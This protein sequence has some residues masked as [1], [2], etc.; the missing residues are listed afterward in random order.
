MLH[1]IGQKVE[2]IGRLRLDAA[3]YD[4][5]P[6]QAE[7]KRGPKPMKG[8]RQP[9]L[10][11]RLADPKTDWKTVDIGWYGGEQKSMEIATGIA[12]WHVPGNHP[13]RLRWILVRPV[14]TQDTSKGAAFFS[15]NVDTAPEQIATCYAQR[16]N[17]EVFFEEVRAC[18]GFETQRGW[19][20]RTIGRT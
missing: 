16:W 19:S 4:D 2:Q 15:T 17:I 14:G 18:L 10:K 8:A 6:Q 9:S 13:A 3:L 12:L 7:S 5:P 1:C 20:N 11:Q